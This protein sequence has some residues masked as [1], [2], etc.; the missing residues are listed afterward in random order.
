MTEAA[1][2]GFLDYLRPY[3]RREAL[4]LLLLGFA[5]GLPLLLVFGTL[6]FW[7]REAGID[8]STIG[9]VSWVASAYAFKFAWAPLVDSWRLPALHGWLGRRRSWMLLAQIGVIAGLVG[10][11]LSDPQLSLSV[12]VA[13]ALLVAFSSATQDIVIDAYRIEIAEGD[14]QAALSASYMAGYRIGMLVSGAGALLIASGV[15]PDP[16]SYVY[17]PWRVAYLAMA[18]AMGAGVLTTLFVCEPMRPTGTAQ[19]RRDFARWLREAVVEPFADFF[20]RYGRTA[21]LLILLIGT[22][23]ITDIVMGAIANV[24]YQDMGYTKAEV[25]S[26]AKVFGVLMTLFGAFVGGAVAPRLGATRVLLVGVVAVVLTNLLF[27]WLAGQAP[28]RWA[29]ALV[30]SADNFS[31]GLASAAFIAYL[32][33]L[34]NVQFSATQYALFSSLMSL[35]PKFLAGFSGVAVD[36]YGYAA[37]FVG[38]SLLGLPVIGLILLLL[39]RLPEPGAPSA[40]DGAPATGAT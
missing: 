29:L 28:T 16:D 18:L 32:S 22:Y 2:A 15:D 40:G 8:R 7:L 34:T 23:R 19:A 26:I 17:A 27:A 13:C 5:A 20:R 3:L 39:R 30:I 21:L 37:F 33:A 9:F 38:C 24:F 14:M 11:A 6:S 10:M 12:T 35:F 1:R 31:V 36:A 25:A 4:S